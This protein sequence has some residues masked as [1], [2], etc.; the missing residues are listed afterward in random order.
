MRNS[1]VRNSELRRNADLRRTQHPPSSRAGYAQE[2]CE[3]RVHSRS[4][5]EK[6]ASALRPFSLH[7]KEWAL[8]GPPLGVAEVQRPLD[9]YCWM[10]DCCR[11]PHCCCCCSCQRPCCCCR[12]HPSLLRDSLGR[13]TRPMQEK[14]GIPEEYA[15]KPGY[16]LCCACAQAAR[17]NAELSE[18]GQEMVSRSYAA[19]ELSGSRCS[20]T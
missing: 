11:R 10:T 19:P 18:C 13:L 20:K 1:E 6:G 17:L 4:L 5:L 3:A 7:W 16:E 12:V 2:C 9:H 15:S 14:A 8:Q